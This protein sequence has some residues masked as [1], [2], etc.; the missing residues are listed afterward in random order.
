VAKNIAIF[1]INLVTPKARAKHEQ[2]FNE[3]ATEAGSLNKSS[4]SAPALGVTKFSVIKDIIL[5]TLCCD[6]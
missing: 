6:T 4:C 2:L 1:V 3:P 5:V